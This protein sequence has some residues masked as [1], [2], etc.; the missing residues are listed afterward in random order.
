ML[1]ELSYKVT[2]FLKW[3][4]CEFNALLY[5]F[6]SG[7][8]IDHR[9]KKI[10][11]LTT[12]YEIKDVYVSTRGIRIVDDLAGPKLDD[13]ILLKDVPIERYICRKCGKIFVRFINT[14]GT[15]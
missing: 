10:H 8:W 9:Y 13:E 5:W 1:R 6:D 14:D 3:S 4:K 15:K 12:E 11:S 7:L 2:K